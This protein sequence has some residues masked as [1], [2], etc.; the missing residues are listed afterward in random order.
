[1]TDLES[2]S[3]QTGRSIR[4]LR[5]W[6]QQGVNLDDSSAVMSYAKEQDLKGLGASRN[7]A[8]KRMT[9]TPSPSSGE[10]AETSF[11]N[12]PSAYD[13]GA[14]AALK[15]LQGFEVDHSRRLGIA[16]A[17]G[18]ELQIRTASEDHARC[19]QVLL[20]YEKEVTEAKRDLGHLIP[21]A[22]A[23]RGAKTSAVWFKLAWRLWLSSSLPDIVAVGSSVGLRDA[24]FKAEET[25]SEILEVSLKNAQEARYSMPL[26]AVSVISDEWHVDNGT[27]SA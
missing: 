16:L 21:K 11:A 23:E 13:E 1:M 14:A 7:R 19:A 6:K 20:K 17:S 27:P 12:L 8:L 9:K 3:K 24:K 4:T 22:D 15:R 18:D 25:F 10:H 5:R 2:L 26:W